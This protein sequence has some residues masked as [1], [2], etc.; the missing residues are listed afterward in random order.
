MAGLLQSF[1]DGVLGLLFPD[2]CAGCGQSGSLFCEQ[3]RAK[4]RPY[5]DHTFPLRCPQEPP[6]LDTITIGYIFE[7]ALRDA[8]HALKYER[9]RRMAEPLGELLVAQARQRPLHIDAL[10]PVPLH[11]RRMAERGFNQSE[12]L[13]APLSRASG[14]P[15]LG[16]GLA[17]Q[18]E[19]AHQVGLDARA[20]LDNVREAFVWQQPAPP[21]AR[22]VLIDD[23]LTTG[24]TLIACAQ[25]LR[26]A[27]T[28]EVRALVL[29]RS[30][31]T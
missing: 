13:A 24:A 16:S 28:R 5:P 14:I 25:T 19:T 2:R 31:L 1:S 11:P 15:L 27:G 29:A 3:C 22:V 21:P 20:R 12:L 17:R 18:R 26:R 10:V 7:G 6:L 9:V 23:V 30:Q 8:I 4:L